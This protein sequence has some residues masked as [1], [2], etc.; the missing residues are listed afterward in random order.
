MSFPAKFASRCVTCTDKIDP[1]AQI[2]RSDGGFVH[3][4]ICEDT[5]DTWDAV[6]TSLGRDR[7]PAKVPTGNVC[8]ECFLVL[9]VVGV[10][11]CR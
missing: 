7:A 5:T 8:P 2:V 4:E 3:A 6:L 1:G 9:P 10:C 11:D